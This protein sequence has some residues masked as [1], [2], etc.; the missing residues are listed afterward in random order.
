MVSHAPKEGFKIFKKIPPQGNK[1]EINL[2]LKHFKVKRKRNFQIQTKHLGKI[3]YTAIFSKNP[4]YLYPP[5]S[6]A[7]CPV[8]RKI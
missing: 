4:H 1:S 8:S 7:C 2:N 6:A 5:H 3:I